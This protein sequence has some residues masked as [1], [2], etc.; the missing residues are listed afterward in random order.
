M[1]K[2]LVLVC[3]TGLLF[4]TVL[5]GCTKENQVELNLES[6]SAYTDQA[7]LISDS[8]EQDISSETIDSIFLEAS[9]EHTKTASYTNLISNGDFSNENMDPWA[10]FM[11]DGSANASVENGQMV[12]SITDEGKVEHG[13]QLY[14]DG[15]SLD[16]GCEYQMECKISS[17]VPRKVHFRI[18]LNSGDYHPYVLNTIDVTPQMQ[19]VTVPFTMN[20]SSDPAP[21]LCF[22]LGCIE[23][24]APLG[25]H[26]I[27]IDDV[28]LYLKDD[29]GKDSSVTNSSNESASPTANVIVNQIGYTPSGQKLVIVRNESEKVHS[30]EFKVIDTATNKEVFSAPLKDSVKNSSAGEYN[31]YGD[32]S[33][34]KKPGSYLIRTS[35]DGDSAPFVIKE[36]IYQDVLPQ[37]FGMLYMQ[38]CGC[39][40]PKQYAGDF[41]HPACHTQKAR[42]YGT[43]Q[44]LDIT[45]GW[46]DA[47]DYGRYVVPGAMTMA[48]LLL[49]YEKHPESTRF[50]G[51]NDS[52]LFHIPES[53]NGIPDLLDEV[54]YEAEFLLKMQAADGGVYHKITCA[55]F[56]GD[57]MP[58]A[59]KDQLFVMPVSTTA[60]GDF[61]AV[62]AKFSVAY[63]PYDERF[64][65]QC[66]DASKKA[67]SFLEAN[68]SI[69]E[70][71]NPSDIATGEYPDGNDSDERMW[72]AAELY[73]ATNDQHYHDAFK[74]LIQSNPPM[75]L[76]WQDMGIF[77]V[78]TYLDT[79]GKTDSE[80]KARL[81]KELL[82]KSNQLIETAKKDGYRISMTN[83]YEWGSNLAVANQAML[84]ALAS[85]YENEP[86]SSLDSQVVIE[87]HLHYLFGR[88]PMAICYVTGFG[89]TSAQHPHHR[90]S[91]VVGA[92]IPGMLVGGP[93]SK[94][95]DPYAAS[96]LSGKA[97][98]KCYA[99]HIQSYSTNEVAIYWN[100]PLL[101]LLCYEQEQ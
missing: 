67:F 15:F 18:Q 49:A 26:D 17:T 46:H 70:F 78:V 38:R 41:S 56:P 90:I 1:K 8:D 24:S 96:V 98:A 97:P 81:K 50:D 3:L 23:Q 37:V 93:N 9:D 11:Q 20:E 58:E 75:G 92:P 99:D 21:R 100:S 57:V 19:T 6:S 10:T 5:N 91:T 71:K 51:F 30:K 74:S 16:S 63:R 84:I 65:N 33:E 89:T 14:H 87:D 85:S 25:A 40:L 79:K 62:M 7:N 13:V 68:P 53:N 42:I 61:A 94:L 31:A 47:G 73:R 4:T 32:F 80:L 95:E 48:D 77:G 45:G 2:N 12:L 36:Q 66:L 88:N 22:N 59:E 27:I 60:T 39:E 52:K 54:R 29:H 76:G 34:F 82:N 83:T 64:A 28:A 35:D 86:K 72:A 44:E 55:N 43:N 69:I 101:F